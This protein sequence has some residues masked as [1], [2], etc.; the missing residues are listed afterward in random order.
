[1]IIATWF[2]PNQDQLLPKYPADAFLMTNDPI[3][4]ESVAEK[5]LEIEIVHLVGGLN[6]SEKY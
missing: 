1:M 2:C 3:F 6:P 5:N 4:R